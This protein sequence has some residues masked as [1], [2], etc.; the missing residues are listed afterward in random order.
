MC[1][2]PSPPSIPSA[3]PPNPTLQRLTHQIPPSNP[4][5][6]QRCNASPNPQPHHQKNKNKNLNASPPLPQ[7]NLMKVRIKT[8]NAVASWRWDVP[9]DDVCGICRVQFDGTCPN[10]RF[11]GD[12]CPLCE[13]PVPSVYAFV[14]VV[15]VAGRRGLGEVVADGSAVQWSGSVGIRFIWYVHTSSTYLPTP[16]PGSRVLF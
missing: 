12:D 9:E 15:V 13:L 6:P 10:C 8:W 2:S 3:P 1:V 5:T 16:A 14:V 11:P 7:K 4:S